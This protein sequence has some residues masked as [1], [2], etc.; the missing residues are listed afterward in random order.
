MKNLKI[1]THALTSKYSIA[2]LPFVNIS[3]EEEN[4]YF[5]DGITEEIINALSKIENLHVT[6]RTSSFAFKNQNTDIREIGRKLNVAL[7]LEGSIRKSGNTVRITAQLSKATDGYHVWSDTWDRELQN[8]FTV[9]DEIAA[10]IA[11]KIDKDIKTQVS[12]TGH[13]I[14]NTNALDW[15]LKGN[16]LLYK[17]DFSERDNII[18]SFEKAIELDPRFIKAFIGLANT[19]TWLG[20]TGFVKPEEAYVKVEYCIKKALSID[21]NIPDIYIII[22]GKKFWIEWDLPAALNNINKALEL[23]PSNSDALKYKGLILAATGRVEEALDSFFQADRL[24]PYSDHIKSSIGMIYNYTNENTKALDYIDQNIQICPYWYAQYMDRIEALCK[25][26]R[27]NEATN[28]IRMLEKDP[29]SPLS[30]AQLKAFLFASQG[31]MKETYEQIRIMDQ[32]LSGSRLGNVPDA[33]FFSKIYLLLGEYDKAL[34]Y[35]EYGMEHRA[36]PFLFIK[37]ESLWD[38]L[39]DHPRYINAIK[40]IKF[41]D[42]KK[43]AEKDTKKYKKTNIPKELAAK[44]EK[45]LEDQMVREKTYL[46][47]ALNLSDLA[48]SVHISNNQLSQILNEAIGKNFYDYVNSY[49]LR[50]FLKVREIPKYRNYTLLSLAY[51]CGFSS[52]TTFNAFFRKTMGMTPSEY[53]KV[54]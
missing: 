48:E 45:M 19:Y 4:E 9:Q 7:I 28:T 15:Y 51:E 12:S 42:S 13:V 2:V 14:E 41:V 34:D 20:S 36:T 44:I 53:F 43:E 46:N 26:E 33:A 5:S 35:L 39:R 40:K 31:K 23:Q 29:D 50:H 27:Y 32:E 17:W 22:A 54:Y 25:L 21:K 1:P 52:K 37:I 8:V 11:E 38:K 18:A 3:S 49:R 30:V 16:Y 10:L 47:P 6:A 24:D